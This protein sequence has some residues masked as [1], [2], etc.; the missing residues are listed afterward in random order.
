MILN[1]LFKSNGGFTLLELVIV[2]AIIAI[3]S[4][5]GITQFGGMTESARESAD[6]ALASEIGSAAKVYM[7]TNNSTDAP[8]LQDL[9]DSK[10]LNKETNTKRQSKKYSP[11]NIEISLDVDSEIVVTFN[12]EQVYPRPT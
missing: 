6:L 8:T 11:G 1:K 5:I 4:V 3:L 9:T 10:Y 2:I 7:A 12:G